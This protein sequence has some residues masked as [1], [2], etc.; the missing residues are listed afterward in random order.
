MPRKFI[1]PDYD[2]TLDITIRLGDVIQSNHLAFFVLEIIAL[3][4]YRYIYAR[5]GNRGAPP[6][7][8]EILLGLLFYS[9]FP[10]S[11]WEYLPRRSASNCRMGL[12][13]GFIV[14]LPT[15]RCYTIAITIF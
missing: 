12:N 3:L 2:A 10:N 4:D 6:Y 13:G 11:I 9:L 8:P 1:T 5:Y 7:A 15:L 14:P